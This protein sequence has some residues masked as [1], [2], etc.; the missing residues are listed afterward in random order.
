ML[1]CLPTHSKSV[2]SAANKESFKDGVTECLEP[3]STCKPG[4]MLGSHY[5]YETCNY[6]VGSPPLK[7]KTGSN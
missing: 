6:Q 1:T 2:G 3:M 5:K 4:L 7:T